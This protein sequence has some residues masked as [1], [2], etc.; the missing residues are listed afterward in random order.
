MTP[1]RPTIPEAQRLETLR[2][3]HLDGMPL[4]EFHRQLTGSGGYEVSY[5]AVRNYH[6]SRKA[7]VDYYAQVSRVFHVRLE[8][9]LFGE[10]EMTTSLQL[11]KESRTEAEAW[12][13]S[14]PRIA[15]SIWSSTDPVSQAAFLD[16]LHRLELARPEARALTP[17]EKQKLAQVLDT[18]VGGALWIL[19]GD[20]RIP[21]DFV[22]YMLLALA[23]GIP[24]PRTGS[25]Y[26][27]IMKR[28]KMG[29]GG[30]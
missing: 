26:K 28:M 10:G 1:L 18:L 24:G 19:R 2:L 17:E 23:H 25:T 4:A 3:Q 29:D 20:R 16:C 22:R 14:L 15:P 11:A 13:D 9:L 30:S 5:A 8:W 12:S 27:G 7:P 21:R 6:S